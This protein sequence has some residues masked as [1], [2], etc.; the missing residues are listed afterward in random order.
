MLNGTFRS[1]FARVNVNKIIIMEHEKQIGAAGRLLQ[2][3]QQFT[4]GH[5]CSQCRA[6]AV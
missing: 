6:D 2:D 4:H 5:C 3:E 1:V